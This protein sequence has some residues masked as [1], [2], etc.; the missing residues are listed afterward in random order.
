MG[1]ALESK[2][3][4]SIVLRH[5]VSDMP[6]DRMKPKTYSEGTKIEIAYDTDEMNSVGASSSGNT[7]KRYYYDDADPPPPSAKI[8][9]HSCCAPCSGA[10]FE[11]MLRKQFNVTIFFYNPNIH[12]RREYNIRKEENKRYAKRHGVPFVDCD[13]DSGSWFARMRGLENDPERLGKR[14]VACFDMRMEVTAAYAYRHGF[15][16]FTTTNATSRWKSES[17]VNGSGLRA[18]RDVARFAHSTTKDNDESSADADASTTRSAPP[19]FWLHSWQTDAFTKRKYEISAEERFYKQEYCG[20][21][22]SLRDSNI[23]RKMNGIDPVRIGGEKA[24]LGTR[25]FEDPNIDAEEES[26]EVVDGFFDAARANF[27]RD[28]D[29]KKAGMKNGDGDSGA[30]AMPATDLGNIYANRKKKAATGPGA[31]SLNNW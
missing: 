25:Y 24:G 8:L 14:C 18:A 15:N 10:M 9:L 3:V 19:R 31:C 20:C 28:S 29:L 7:E 26:Q 16:A 11:E 6:F 12:P 30:R 27:R 21:S 2:R 13:Y 5:H 4:D 1:N 23:W 22:Y 17:Q